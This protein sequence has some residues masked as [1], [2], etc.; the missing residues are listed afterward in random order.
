M[1]RDLNQDQLEHISKSKLLHDNRRV[2]QAD[3]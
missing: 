3:K 2:R 1:T